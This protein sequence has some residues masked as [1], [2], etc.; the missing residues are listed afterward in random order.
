MA[1]QLPK[2]DLF[3]EV[4]FISPF[5]SPELS[6]ETECPLSPLLEPK[7]CP[8]GHQNVDLDNDEDSTLPLHD[9][10]PK[11]KNCCAMDNLRAPT[12][13]VKK[14][15]STNKHEGFPFETPKVSCSLLESLELITLSATCFYEDHNHLL[16]LVYK[17]FRRMVVDAYVYQKYCRSHRCTVVLTLQLEQ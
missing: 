14:N 9:I 7:P 12:L 13:E 16:V 17:H 10:S 11:N 5:I 3:E 2:H 4:K 1:K 6:C 15:N 8:S